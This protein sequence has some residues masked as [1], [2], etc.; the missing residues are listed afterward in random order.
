MRKLVFIGLVLLLSGCDF[1]Q[2]DDNDGY[3]CSAKDQ[4]RFVRDATEYW[5]LWNDLLPENTRVKNYSGPV[6]LLADLIQV[7][8]L[9]TFSY[10]GSAFADAAFFGGGQYE[11][12]GF[13][14]QRFANDDFRLTRV[15]VGSP[16]DEAGLSRGQRI[17][18]VE[19]RPIAEI[20]ADEG[21]GSAL[22]PNSAELTLLET[23]GVTEFTVRVFK[24]VVTIDPV[25]QWRLIDTANGPPVGYLELS[26]FVATADPQLQTAFSEFQV[27]GVTDL[28]IDLRYNGGGLV[29]TAELLGNLLGGNVA[30]DLVFTETRFNADR[31][32]D[33]DFA[34]VFR[35]LT[36][37]ISLSRLVVIA[38]STTAS[39]S[40]LVINGLEPHVDVAVVGDQTFGKPVGQVGL[41]FCGSILRLT[42]FQNFNAD[43][44]GDYFDG[45]PAD[46]NAA[47]DLDLAVGDPDDPN[48]IA[49]M[50]YLTSGACPPAPAPA[51][52]LRRRID[53]A[54]SGTERQPAWREFAGA[55]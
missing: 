10:I 48:M 49:A 41:E 5:Y 32:A 44:F 50:S 33:Q 15:F 38:S 2:D 40:E 23:D 4:K 20:D 16:A 19:G 35:N 29:S 45:L 8:P 28:I 12:F 42:A 14:W 39:A 51:A 18:A 17:V 55:W 7:Q 24:S 27:N 36:N 3:T 1:Y 30:E 11:G 22:E 13:S 54:Q 46:C 6:A 31:A 53:P 43:G 47:D 26:T 34:S 21:L 25:P 9:D 37:T 52:E